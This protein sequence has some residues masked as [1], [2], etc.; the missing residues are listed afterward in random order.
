MRRLITVLI[1]VG[2]MPI[3]SDCA[4]AIDVLCPPA[5][6]CPNVRPWHEAD[7]DRT[8]DLEAVLTLIYPT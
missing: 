8:L 6:Q 2:L 7:I 3:L 4:N 1:H 5:G